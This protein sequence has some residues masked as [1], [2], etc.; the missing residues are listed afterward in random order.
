MSAETNRVQVEIAGRTYTL[1]GGRDP[2]LVTELAAFVDRRMTEIG[3]QTT[4]A[5]TAR[6]AILAA[7]NIADELFQTRA[8]GGKGLRGLP[9]SARDSRLCEIL[10]EALAG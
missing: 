3:D 8:A 2:Q 4:T 5:D 1:K 10:D 6:L 9:D 7:L